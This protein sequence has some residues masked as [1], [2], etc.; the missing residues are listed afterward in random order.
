MF[1]LPLSSRIPV[2]DIDLG[3][4]MGLAGLREILFPC[5][6]AMD[7]LRRPILAK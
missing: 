2:W 4:L 6:V 3:S 1:L 7:Q 5:P